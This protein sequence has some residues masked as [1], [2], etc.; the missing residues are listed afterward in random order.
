MQ[1]PEKNVIV[2]QAP[3]QDGHIS[4][5]SPKTGNLADQKG[6]ERMNKKQETRRDFKN[7]TMLAFSMILM[8]SWEGVLSTSAIAFGNGGRAG[9]LYTNLAVWLGFIA[10]PLLRALE[11][12]QAIRQYH[13]VSELAPK[14]WQKL[15]SYIVGWLG[16]LGWQTG[17]AFSG[18]LTG[19]QIQGLLVLNYPGYVF[20]RWHGTLLI[21]AMLSFAVFFNTVLAHRLPLVEGLILFIHVFGFVG[22]FA[23]LLALS[24]KASHEAVWNTF[25]DPG[26]NNTGLSTLIGGLVA[27]TAPLLG[28]DAAGKSTQLQDAAYTLPRVMTLATFANGL[29]AFVMLIAICYCI[30][31]ID[32]VLSTPTG[33]PFIQIFYNTTG[34]LAATNAMTAFIIILSASSCITIMAGSSRQLFAFARDDGLPFSK[35]VAHVRP[36]LD[37][38]VNA[39]LFSFTFAACISLV[40]IGSTAA[41]NSITS[42]GTGTLT[43]SYI[44]CLS[45]MIWLRINGKPLLPSRFDL[46]RSFGLT[47]N[48]TAVGFLVLVFVI[49]FF[50]PVPEPLLT[51]VMM[52]WSILIFG[53][54]VL[55]SMLYYFL[56]G[57]KV[58]VGPVEYV[59]VLG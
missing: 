17:I 39:I 46:G 38:P 26:W 32:A 56:W 30:G 50:P 12:D 48:V 58:Y 44:I 7:V 40:N 9:A 59:R 10:V 5:H 43:I 31:D 53:V 15:L 16:V 13:W 35:W 54:V 22:I 28:A 6:M 52:N 11:A 27:A 4:T 3:T 47:L 37:V 41:F 42:L 34:S 8:C 57:R 24:P 55:F 33:Y 29:M 19:T 18:Y 20:E 45:C 14:R 21:I 25:Y 51:V 1:A 2:S 49:A 23:T 36:G